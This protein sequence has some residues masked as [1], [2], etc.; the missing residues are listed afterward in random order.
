MISLQERYQG[1]LLGLAT[2]DALGTTLEFKP[3]GSFS[4]LEDLVGGGPFYLE[5]GQWTDDTSMALCLAQS[6]I[7]S[8]G[9]DARDQMHRYC[10]WWKNGTLSSTGRCFD[11][12]TTVANA[13]HSFLS[14]GDAF[15]GDTHPLTAGNGSLMRLVPVVMYFHPNLDEVQHY[16][17]E[18]SRTTHG[19]RECLEACRYFACLLSACFSGASKDALLK[20]FAF[21]STSKKVQKIAQGSYLDKPMENIKGTGYVIDCLE[22]ALRCFADSDNFNDAILLAANLGDDADTTA[23]V[24][25]QLAGAF[26]G[27]SGIRQDWQDKIFM[28]AEILA[29]ADKLYQTS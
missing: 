1:A 20:D 2:G 14:N 11:I 6:L 24:C 29:F 22:A 28:R 18:S 5:A 15:A 9:F 10:D 16:A 26:Y 13:L 4:P 27:V 7:E 19:S 17:V 25:G 23:A 21:I 12:G 8:Q 3:P